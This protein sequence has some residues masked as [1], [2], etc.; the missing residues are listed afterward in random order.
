MANDYGLTKED[1]LQAAANRTRLQNQ[2]ANVKP[3][4]DRAGAPMIPY[5]SLAK[6][7]AQLSAIPDPYAA[8]YKD[9][10]YQNYKNKAK[11]LNTF[12][13]MLQ[14]A[15]LLGKGAM[16]ADAIYRTSQ[17]PGS[18]WD[19]M[20]NQSPGNVV[21][22]TSDFPM[23]LTENGSVGTWDFLNPDTLPMD[24]TDYAGNIVDDALGYVDWGDQLWNGAD[25]IWSGADDLSWGWM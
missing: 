11:G 20:F 14:Y 24:Y 21:S 16:G 23:N 2:M 3:V 17:K 13:K 9:Q 1:L 5:G 19:K 4:Y 8:S 15:Q 10:L 12:Q 6:L 7:Q 25:N 18:L 22:D